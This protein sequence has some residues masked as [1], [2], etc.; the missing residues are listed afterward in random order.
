MRVVEMVRQGTKVSYEPRS[1]L[2]GETRSFL[3]VTAEDLKKDL[4]YDA[5]QYLK[6]VLAIIKRFLTRWRLLQLQVRTRKQQYD[7]ATCN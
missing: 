5:A 6:V 7:G 1:K 4:D 3:F 2:A